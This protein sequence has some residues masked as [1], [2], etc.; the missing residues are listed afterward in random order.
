VSKDAISAIA[1][2]KI[3]PT[4]QLPSSVPEPEDDPI[5]NSIIIPK[6]INAVTK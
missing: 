4:A 6:V 3:I 1:K 5:L 2:P